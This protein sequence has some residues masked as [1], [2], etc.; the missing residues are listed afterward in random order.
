DFVRTRHLTCSFPGC[1]AP[2]VHCDIDHVT[3][4]PAGPTH[5]GNL[6]P[7]CR[8]HHLLKTFYRGPDGW[9][10]E[11][12]ADG[13]VIWT[14]PT[15]HVYRNMPLSRILFPDKNFDT[16]LPPV[17][18]PDS[19]TGLGRGVMMPQRR[20]TRAHNRAARIAYERTLNEEELAN[21]HRERRSAAT[22]ET[23]ERRGQDD[24]F[25]GA[26]PPDGIPPPF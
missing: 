16:P 22:S 25:N 11:Q 14:A 26:H 23:D 20:R 8:K 5:P 7:K 12:L 24:I 13:T 17:S 9:R 2:A 15:G 18:A 4:W 6:S 10:D 21:A 3:P 1:D 19:T